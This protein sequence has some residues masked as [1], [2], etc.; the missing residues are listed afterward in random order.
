MNVKLVDVPHLPMSEKA[1][2]RVV[3][4]EI[5]GRNPALEALVKWNTD[6]QFRSEYTKIIRAMTRAASEVRVTDPKQ[7][8]R[9]NDGEVFE[10]RAH[11]GKAR[12]MFFYDDE[13]ESL[14]VCTHDYWKGSGH[15]KTAQNQAFNVCKKLKEVYLR[16]KRN[17]QKK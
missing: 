8:G 16:W 2:W 4:L 15:S 12:L 5:N 3:T 14:I 7:V 11:R 10:L 1:R 17:K 13:G 9:S 6:K